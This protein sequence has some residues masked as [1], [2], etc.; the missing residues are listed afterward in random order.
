MQNSTLTY[1]QAKLLQAANGIDEKL[2]NNAL[3][4]FFFFRAA[5]FCRPPCSPC[6]PIVLAGM[7][8]NQIFLYIS[9]SDVRYFDS[10]RISGWL[11]FVVYL[12]IR[13]YVM[14]YIYWY[15][16]CIVSLAYL[17]P[18]QW[19]VWYIQ[20]SWNVGYWFQLLLTNQ[21]QCNSWI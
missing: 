14:V 17:S 5:S 8:D 7:L 9:Q 20:C 16:V 18:W 21:I 19:L 12:V 4:K 15:L 1:F 11:I 10:S 3:M 2:Q 6:N 13:Y